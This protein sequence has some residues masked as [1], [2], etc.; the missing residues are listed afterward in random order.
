MNE[1]SEGGLW[2]SEKSVRKLLNWS[3]FEVYDKCANF[4]F[5]NGRH[6]G[7]G[8]HGLL[9]KAVI[10]VSFNNIL[11]LKDNLFSFPYPRFL[12]NHFSQS[13][14]WNIEIRLESCGNIYYRRNYVIVLAKMVETFLKCFIMAN[15]LDFEAISVLAMCLSGTRHMILIMSLL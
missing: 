1:A 6:I 3:N 13:V 5:E 12:I 15:L 7:D 4:N 11:S 14:V 2:N 9:L 8:N 10:T